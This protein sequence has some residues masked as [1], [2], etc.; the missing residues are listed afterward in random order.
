MPAVAPPAV[1]NRALTFIE[2][3]A[4]PSGLTFGQAFERDPWLLHDVLA[5][6]MALNAEG[7]P[8]HRHA[9]IELHR[10]AGKTTLA[11]AIS[12]IEALREPETEIVCI[13]ADAAQARLLLTALDGFIRRSPRL[14]AAVRRTQNE[15][16]VRGNGSRIRI[17]SSD[18]PSFY[19]IGAG[20]RRLRIVG[21]E[22]GQWQKPDLWHA[23][24]STLPKLADAQ[25][26]AITNAGISGSWQ[27]EVRETV[28]GHGYLYAP[29]GLV[30]SWVSRA[31]VEAARAV[32]PE[33]LY[34]RYYLNQW[35][36]ETSTAI[37][38]AEW[39]ACR[40]D[41]P[42]LTPAELCVVGID[43]GVRHDAFGIV[44]VSR[45]QPAPVD[46]LPEHYR[47]PTDGPR[48]HQIVNYDLSQRGLPFGLSIFENSEGDTDPPEVWV[49]QIKVWTPQGAALDFGQPYRWLSEFVRSH[50]VENICFDPFQL[51]S[52]AQ[53]FRAEHGVWMS[54]FAQGPLRSQADVALL[55]LVRAGRLKHDGDPALR[56]HML[57][58]ALK[59]GVGEDSKG[60]LIKA[61]P[62]KKID[63]AVA[64]SMAA[65]QVLRLVL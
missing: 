18:V 38:A 12:F 55:Q 49:R 16:T 6:V 14:A 64:L 8:L 48:A 58:A 2:G 44:V 10:G 22:I 40:A 50:H 52:W 32:L 33:P 21:D 1:D 27:A 62:S 51:H 56:E 31:D 17:E 26:L 57:N 25:L 63:A 23:A 13:A 15:F 43:A 24:V 5:P 28:A 54:E 60:R 9:W 7:L 3:L 36:N 4:L 41:L 29:A 53:N 34:R 11:A 46:N 20:C 42:P 37:D 65:H 45:G 59:V 47:S 61:A 39:D 19:G 30:A 35:I